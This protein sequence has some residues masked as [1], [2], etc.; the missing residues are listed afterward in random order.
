M[1][2]W[3]VCAR[4]LARAGGRGK[5]REA[6]QVELRVPAA[7]RALQLRAEGLL[8]ALIFPISKPFLCIKIRDNN[9]RV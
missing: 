7:L 6:G 1:C 9:V 2:V 3:C 5:A 4:E 8:F